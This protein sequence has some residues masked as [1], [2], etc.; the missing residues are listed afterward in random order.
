MPSGVAPADAVEI[1]AQADVV[2]AGDFGD[3]VDVIDQR[4]QGRARNFGGPLALDAVRVEVGDGFSRGLELVGVGLDG[5]VAVFGL[6]FLGLAVVLVDEG[7]VEIYL[8]DAAVLGDGA[9]HVVG[10]VARMIGEGARGRVRGDQRRFADGDGIVERLVGDVRD[11]DQHAQAV[12]LED[13]LLAAVGEAV[14]VLDFGIVDV[15]RRVGPFVGVRPAQGHV[16]HAEA[17]EIA[18]QANVVFDGVA[19]FNAEQCGKF[20]FAVGALDVGDAESHHHAVGM[21]GGLL[22]DRIDEIERVAGEVAL[23]GF[24]VHPD[25]EELGAEIAGLG[26]VEADVA[27]VFGIG[28]SDVVVFVEKALRRVGVRVDD[29]GGV[30]DLAGLGADG[31]LRVCGNDKSERRS[32]GKNAFVHFDLRVCTRILYESG[33]LRA[34]GFEPQSSRSRFGASQCGE[35]LLDALL[36]RLVGGDRRFGICNRFEAGFHFEIERERP[37]VRGMRGVGFEVETPAGGFIGTG[38]LDDRPGLSVFAGELENPV[39]LIAAGE[40]AAVEEDFAGGSILQQ[41]TG[42][43]EHD[44]HH[45]VVLLDGV[46]DIV[47]REQRGADFIFAEE[48]AL[49]AAGQFAGE[50]GLAGSRE[51]RPSEQ[52]F[53]GECSGGV[54][55]GGDSVEALIRQRRW[56]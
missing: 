52:S 44:L 9:Q 5:G 55:E 17:V 38:A 45:E 25:G 22:I 48:R 21:A 40:G 4:F 50:R 14:V 27:G 12:H 2:D 49:S 13:D 3:V 29:D 32:G 6:G 31:G 53:C 33:K 36:K 30:V 47:W 28:R 16:A 56:S 43:V 26:L 20:V 1:R 35:S 18:E 42:G 24:R 39:D 11:V 8:D 41:E 15:A 23:V 54:A 37:V 7:A 19:A 34:S 51:D 46:F 10:H